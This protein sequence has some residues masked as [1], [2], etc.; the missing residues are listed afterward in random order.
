MPPGGGGTTRS[1]RRL[2][3]VLLPRDPPTKNEGSEVRHV[4]SKSMDEK[5]GGWSVENTTTQP[6][7]CSLA[8]RLKRIPP[9]FRYRGCVSNY[10]GKLWRTGKGVPEKREV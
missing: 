5:G 1:S 4:S 9:H 7:R 8:E 2:P 6:G 10:R 3:V